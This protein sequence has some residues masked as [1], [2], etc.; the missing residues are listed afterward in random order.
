MS[1]QAYYCLPDCSFKAAT[2]H[3]CCGA[4][5]T[6]VLGLKLSIS[7]FFDVDKERLAGQMLSHFGIT[8]RSGLVLKHIRDS[9]YRRVGV[10]QYQVNDE[11]LR[12]LDVR[13]L[14]KVIII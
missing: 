10:Y 3:R 13:P 14:Q 9:T 6:D 8:S 5:E 2:E 7:M 1:T 12:P 11:K 4:L